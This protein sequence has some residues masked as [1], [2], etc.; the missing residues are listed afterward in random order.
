MDPRFIDSQ[1]RCGGVLTMRLLLLA[2]ILVLQ[3]GTSIQEPAAVKGS[4]DEIR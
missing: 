1:P 4:G 2:G 3:V